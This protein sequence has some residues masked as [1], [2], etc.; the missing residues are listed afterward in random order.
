MLTTH[1]HLVPRLRMSR[2]IPLL[3]LYA[4]VH[5][6]GDLYLL[7]YGVIFHK[8]A[9]LMLTAQRI[10]NITYGFGVMGDKFFN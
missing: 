8:H 3:H 2:A 9:L 7:L 6:W 10:I 1:L 4:L 5:E